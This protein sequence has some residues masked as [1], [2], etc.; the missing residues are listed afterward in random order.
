MKW[1]TAIPTVEIDRKNL[2]SA[3]LKS[4]TCN[5]NSH[6][7]LPPTKADYIKTKKVASTSLEVALSRYCSEE[8]TITPITNKDEVIRQQLA[9]RVPQNYR[10]RN[11]IGIDNPN[12]PNYRFK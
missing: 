12:S 1:L 9:F 4:S 8:C 6:D 3:I 11:R 2:K 7:H 5:T 10:A